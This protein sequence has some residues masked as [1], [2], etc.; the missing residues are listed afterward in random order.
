MDGG[1]WVP[2]SPISVVAG[3]EVYYTEPGAVLQTVR[4]LSVRHSHTGGICATTDVTTEYAPVIGQF[5]LPQY[6]PPFTIE[7]EACF[8][9]EDPDPEQIINGCVKNKGGTL[10][11]VADPAECTPRETPITLLSP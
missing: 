5:T 1:S 8:T 11:I 6:T 7:P 3:Q 2:L 4:V 9:P 10:R